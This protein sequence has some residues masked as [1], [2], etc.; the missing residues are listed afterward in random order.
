ML[1][2]KPRDYTDAAWQASV[3]DADLEKTILLGGAGVGKSPQ[4]PAQPQLEKQPEVLHALVAIVRG[5]KK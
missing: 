4:M 5:F 1:Q 2:T 3:T